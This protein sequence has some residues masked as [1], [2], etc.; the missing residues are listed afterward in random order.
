MLTI[1]EN[2]L[3]PEIRHSACPVQR[4]NWIIERAEEAGIALPLIIDR[5]FDGTITIKGARNEPVR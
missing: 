1:F 3:P 5:H 4:G 2:D